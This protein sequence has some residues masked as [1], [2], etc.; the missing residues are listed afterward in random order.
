LFHLSVEVK[1]SESTGAVL[2]LAVRLAD[3]N[4]RWP[5]ASPRKAKVKE[6]PAVF[7]GEF[8]ATSAMIAVP[9][10]PIQIRKIHLAPEAMRKLLQANIYGGYTFWGALRYPLAGF[11]ACFLPLMFFGFRLDRKRNESARNGRVLRGPRS[12]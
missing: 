8:L 1:S 12:R 9:P 10:G 4:S 7:A 2:L 3:L 11:F 6:Y 5:H